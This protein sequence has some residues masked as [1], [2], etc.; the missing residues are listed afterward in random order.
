MHRVD[1]MDQVADHAKLGKNEVF[2]RKAAGKKAAEKPAGTGKKAVASKKSE[3]D[4]DIEESEALEASDW[5]AGVFVTCRLSLSI[6]I[7]VI[8][9][10]AL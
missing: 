8:V 7:Y 6:G 4:L 5:E 9:H 2:K 1:Q 10:A 3:D